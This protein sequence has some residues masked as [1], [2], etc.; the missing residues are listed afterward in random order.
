MNYKNGFFQLFHKTDG[1]WLKI[2][3]PLEDGQ[4][5]PVTELTGYLDDRNVPYDLKQLNEFIILAQKPS[6]KKMTEEETAPVDE[7]MRLTVSDD[8]MTVT[9]RFYPPSNKG[10]LLKKQEILG[11]LE[12]RGVRHGIQEQEI[13][14][15]LKNR[16]FCR[17]FVFAKGTPPQTGKNAEII[18]YF[19]MEATSKPK[20]NEDG[21]VDFHQLDNISHVNSGDVL[22]KL[23][24]ADFGIQGTDV[25]GNS[26][27]PP[28]IN[29]KILRHGNH[30][31]LSEDGQTM[32]ADVSGHV[33]MA[34]D[35]VFV[36]NTYEV[37]ADV[38]AS[39]GDIEY[40]GNVLVRGN[41][42]TGFTVRAKGDIIVEGVVE[43]A[44][45][46]A[47]GQIVLKR[48][49]QGMSRGSLTADGDIV[50]KFIENSEVFAGG[51]I[52]TDAI[53]HSRVS[54]NED[55]I[56]SG[57][58]GLVTGGEIK[59]GGMITVKTA[60]SAMGTGTV[61]EV[62]VDLSLLEAYTRLEKETAVMQQEK[63]K[64]EQVLNLFKRKLSQ[65]D[66]LP[67]DKMLLIKNA[68]QTFHTLDEKINENMEK[69]LAYK[70]EMDSQEGGRIKV[71]NMAYPGVKLIIA[72]IVYYVKT[73]THH[74]QFVRDRGDIRILSI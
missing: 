40:D 9:A 31:H 35:R 10:K 71:E 18:Y 46:I 32:I 50:S 47:G 24:P 54:A 8:R 42:I 63:E 14:L 11:D 58:R 52:N 37:P 7:C 27:K 22:A 49:I 70:T 20:I 45:L 1:T 41:V 61:I 69:A 34:D 73:E 6:E 38:G 62:G 30:I 4:P 28:K 17:N 13:D 60:G 55:I 66:K 59:A 67:A 43:G 36:S 44:Q 23:V 5:V 64:A 2:F 16:Q 68:N 56:V 39:T 48:G 53:M 29:N 33:S 65:G 15:F 12:H 72:N 57:K 3:P 19:N 74:C 51:T 25:A 26:I 21:S